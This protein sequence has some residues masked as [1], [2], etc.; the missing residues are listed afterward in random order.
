MDF[1]FSFGWMF[2]GL[3]IALAGGLIVFFYRPI[4]ENLANGV[5]SYEK[6][7]LFGVITVV[8]GL[9]VTMNLHIF[10]LTFITN[11]LFGRD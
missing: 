4:A 10:I 7:K 8:V 1:T 2:G 5:S 9:L 11:L 6:V 3:A